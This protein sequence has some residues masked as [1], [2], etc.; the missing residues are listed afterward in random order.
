MIIMVGQGGEGSPWTHGP[1]SVVESLK[2]LVEEY[3][4]P[5]Q[6]LLDFHDARGLRFSLFKYPLTLC[7]R[8]CEEPLAAGY[9]HKL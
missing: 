3:A 8:A 7:V 9:L 5:S 6:S 4:I 1:H 2:R